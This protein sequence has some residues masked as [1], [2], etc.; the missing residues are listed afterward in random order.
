MRI[1]HFE[2][3]VEEPSM[4]VLLTAVM[5]RLLGGRAS[6]LI[7]S[8]QGKSDLLKK[9]GPKLRAYSRWLPNN[10]RVI[11]VIDRDNDDCSQLKRLMDS[12][13]I[14]AGFEIRSSCASGKWHVL[15]RIAVE[16]LEAWYFGEWQAVMVA[17]PKV[18]S[19]VPNQSKYRQPDAITGGT[20]ESL[21]RILKRAGYFESG[22][23]KIEAAEAIGKHLNPKV[24]T[25]PS[26][27]SLRDAILE[28]LIP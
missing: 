15:N 11:V 21:E 27:I 7:H 16:E 12:A 25:S 19:S 18:P 13:A 28:A 24:C 14:S 23:R 8:H 9:L 4:E 2:V 1:E 3:L 10:A 17:Y 5:P 6:F 26:F 20:W 22:L